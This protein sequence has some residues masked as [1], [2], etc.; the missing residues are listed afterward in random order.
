MRER[1]ERD[2][3]IDRERERDRE[4]DREREREWV[5]FDVTE[6]RVIAISIPVSK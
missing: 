1:R 5:P 6:M 4:I 3:E 2:K